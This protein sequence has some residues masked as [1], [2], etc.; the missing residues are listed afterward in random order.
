V[1]RFSQ[2]AAS[3]RWL[4]GRCCSVFLV[5]DVKRCTR[6]RRIGD[7]SGRKAAGGRGP[8]KAEGR[9]ASSGKRSSRVS[10]DTMCIVVV[11]M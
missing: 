10:G 11:A 7:N 2:F 5:L 9:Q 1:R 4:G 6:W 8:R 3:D